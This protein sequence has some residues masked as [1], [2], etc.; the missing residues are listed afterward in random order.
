MKI[1]S[2]IVVYYPSSIS[3]ALSFVITIAVSLFITEDLLI[4]YS[5]CFFFVFC[6]SKVSYDFYFIFFLKSTKNEGT[7]VLFICGTTCFFFLLSFSVLKLNIFF[8]HLFDMIWFCVIYSCTTLF[9][10]SCYYLIW[11]WSL[12]QLGSWVSSY[13]MFF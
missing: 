11:V 8:L 3:S 10:I 1:S 12:E 4:S 9:Y 13:I 5:F 7:V 6:L 2:A